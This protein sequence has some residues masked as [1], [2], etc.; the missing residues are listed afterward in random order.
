M[1]NLEIEQAKFKQR[2]QLIRLGWIAL[3]VFI[4][5]AFALYSELSNINETLNAMDYNLQRIKMK[6][7]N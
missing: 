3:I 4:L 1:S 7:S 5:V 2:Q 6:L